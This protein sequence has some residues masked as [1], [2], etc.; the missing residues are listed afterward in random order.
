MTAGVRVKRGGGWTGHVHEE[1]HSLVLDWRVPIPEE[2]T[3]C[4]SF[5]AFLIQ[6]VMR[7]KTHSGEVSHILWQFTQ[8][9]SPQYIWYSK[10]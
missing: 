3:G 2:G 5:S 8:M 6:E 4:I 1:Q 9:G 10:S 7:L